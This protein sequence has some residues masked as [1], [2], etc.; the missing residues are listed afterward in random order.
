MCK[1]NFEYLS[2]SATFTQIKNIPMKKTLFIAALICKSLLSYSQSSVGLIAHWDMNN[3][4]NDVSG[5][6]HNGTLHNVVADTGMDGL[7]NTAYS[8]NGTNSYITAPYLPDLNLSTYSICA[9]IKIK[10]F[11]SGFCQVNSI[12]YRGPL[13]TSGNYSLFFYDNPYDGDNCSLIDT[14]KDVFICEYGTYS[15]TETLW[16]YTPTITED[17]WYRVVA[18]WDG[19]HRN[20][21]VNGILKSSPLTTGGSIG[22]STDSISIGSD[23][24][25]VSPTG[26]FTGLMDDIRLYNRV[27]TDSEI[28]HYGDSCGSVTLQPVSDTLTEG[29]NAT[30]VVNSTITSAT[31]QWQQDAGTGFVNLTNSGP[32]SGVF[33]NTLTISGATVALS[34]DH[35]R[36][37]VSNL[38]GCADTSA[39][40]LL[41]SIPSSVNNVALNNDDVAVYPNPA[42]NSVFIKIP[43]GNN[44]GKIQLMNNVG[45]VIS[46]KSINGTNCELSTADLAAGIYIVRIQLNGQVL[47][48]KIVKK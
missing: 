19:T 15:S 31:Y 38:S 42:V 39:S 23:I 21:Y 34:N 17:Q 9:I 37:I 7:P 32:Y 11:Y 44:T 43:T 8:F 46:E 14:T 18:T 10:G 40:A 48:K 33:T 28:V 22:S 3:E 13:S 12:F 4:A 47:Y 20:I 30:Y 27:L 24:F 16:Q 6:G 35:Y 36:C 1:Y 26:R 25:D 45:Q 5:N 41:I 2:A 29:G